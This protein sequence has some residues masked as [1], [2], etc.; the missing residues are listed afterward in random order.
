MVDM[1]L[2]KRALDG[3]DDDDSTPTPTNEGSVLESPFFESRAE[4]CLT[5]NPETSSNYVSAWLS[6]CQ[7]IRSHN[8]NE[9]EERS[10]TPIP[11]QRPTKS[12]RTRTKSKSVLPM[13]S[14]PTAYTKPFSRSAYPTLRVSALTLA[15]TEGCQNEGGRDQEEVQVRAQTPFRLITPQSRTTNIQNSSRS[16]CLD[17][18]SLWSRHSSTLNMRKS[19]TGEDCEED[20]LEGDSEIKFSPARQRPNHLPLQSN[21]SIRRIGNDGVQNTEALASTKPVKPFMFWLFNNVS[22]N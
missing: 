16:R 18:A 1:E 6:E 13:D 5:P 4:D 9:N 3:E 2:D 17:S 12:S 11:I 20:G 7:I 8:E 10:L 19:P 22:H 14:P 15:R 21:T